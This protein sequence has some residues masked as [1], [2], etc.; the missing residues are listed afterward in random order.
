[1]DARERASRVGPR[2]DGR[3]ARRGRRAGHG[4]AVLDM[5]APAHQFAHAGGVAPTAPAQRPTGAAT[6][7]ASGASPTLLTHTPVQGKKR[8][9]VPLQGTLHPAPT[10]P[11][12]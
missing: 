9:G 12:E 8:R 5:E 4:G 2:Y 10:T 11:N 3:I 7:A 1:M 6:M